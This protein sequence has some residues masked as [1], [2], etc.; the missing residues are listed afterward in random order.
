VLHGSRR[1]GPCREVHRERG[2]CR[3]ARAGSGQGVILFSIYRFG[4]YQ[5]FR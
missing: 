1:E 5:G 3:G 2:F 4:R